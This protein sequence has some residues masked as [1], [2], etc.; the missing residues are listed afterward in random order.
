MEDR[1]IIGCLVTY[2]GQEKPALAFFNGKKLVGDRS[3]AKPYKQKNLAD[4][5]AYRHYGP[6]G[7]VEKLS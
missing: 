6:K 5:I 4:Q 2:L 7:F 1:F 3:L